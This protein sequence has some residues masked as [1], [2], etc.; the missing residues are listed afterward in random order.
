MATFQERDFVQQV[1]S[2]SLTGNLH[3]LPNNPD[4]FDAGHLQESI[5]ENEIL[6]LHAR[7]IEEAQES[8]ANDMKSAV[9]ES[10]VS[11]SEESISSTPNT[12]PN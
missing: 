1:I 10:T 4:S 3:N 11:T 6:T 7:S 9:S 12:L 5:P 2:R 8:P